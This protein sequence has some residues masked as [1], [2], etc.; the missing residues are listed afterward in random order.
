MTTAGRV[1]A[2]CGL[3]AAGELG[4]WAATLDRPAAVL[5]SA[6]V[7]AAFLV[8]PP[9]FLALIAWRRQ[10]HPV[11]P[12]RFLVLACVLGVV[13]LAVL[14]WDCYRYQTDAEFR[15]VRNMN[16]VVVPLG[17]W[18]AVLAV[19][20]VVVVSEAREKRATAGTGPK[21]SR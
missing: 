21:Q 11:W 6:L 8:G 16:A 3:T 19:W 13:G 14:G 5:S 4:L 12:R 2:V 20:V 18:A 10:G 9:A 17:Q 1:V 7:M 15:K